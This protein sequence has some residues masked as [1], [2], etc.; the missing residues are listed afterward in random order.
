MCAKGE[1]EAV[2]VSK[3]GCGVGTPTNKR[4]ARW[5]DRPM[6]AQPGKLERKCSCID[7]SWS[8][9]SAAWDNRSSLDERDILCR[10]GILNSQ[11]SILISTFFCFLI[12]P[13]WDL[14][15]SSWFMVG[16]LFW[17]F[18]L[19]WPLFFSRFPPF[20]SGADCA[21]TAAVGLAEQLCL[22]L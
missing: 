5:M 9:A 2:E 21:W 20:F 10:R 12:W 17:F 4:R 19:Q 6:A 22:G 11:F 18:F 3:V 13:K 16:A 8:S 1:E 15:L 7:W 14:V